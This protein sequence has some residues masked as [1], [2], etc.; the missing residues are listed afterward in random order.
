MLFD[1]SNV[2]FV[3][4]P[5]SCARLTVAKPSATQAKYLDYEIG[6]SIHF[7]MQTFN[8]NMKPDHFSG[9]LL[10][11]TAT[12]YNYSVKNSNWRN[13]T[14]DVA[15]E[16]MQSCAN[17]ALSH[18]FYYSVHENWYMDVDNYKTHNPVTQAVYRRLVEEHLREL[19]SPKSKYKK[20]F[21]FW[22]DAGIV[23]GISPNVGPILRLFS[24]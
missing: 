18:G 15:W 3:P 17:T 14:G 20:P 21:L 6:A 2:V 10:W 12:N 24:E 4:V 7:N 8:R 22:F 23:P 1:H 19:L 11:P 13:G 16:F 5:V 9:F